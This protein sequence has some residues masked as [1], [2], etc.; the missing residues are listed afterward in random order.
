M[1]RHTATLLLAAISSNT[2]FC[3]ATQVLPVYIEDNHAG[4]YYWLTENLDVN[5]K[6]TLINFDAHS[7]ASAIFDS[8]VIRNALQAGA[9]TKERALLIDQWR[10][11]GTIQ[12]FSWIEPLMPAPIS[13]VIWVPGDK[14]AEVEKTKREN[15]A[16]ALIDGNLEAAPRKTGSLHNRFTV[17]D[18]E[19]LPTHVSDQEPLVV[20]IDLDYFSGLSPEEQS[21]SFKRVWDFVLKQ[22][23]LQAVTFAISRPYLVDENEANRLLKHAFNAPLLLPLMRLQ[24]EPFAAVANDQSTRAKDLKAAGHPVPSYSVEQAPEGLRAM[25]LAEKERIIVKRDTSRWETLLQKWQNEAPQFHLE[26]KG[27]QPSTDG[28]W[29]VPANKRTTIDVLTGSLTARPEHVDWSILTPRYLSC[30]VTDLRADQVGFVEN[31]APRPTWQEIAIPQTDTSLQVSQ[32]D[33]YFD[34]RSKTGSIRL[35]ASVEIDGKIR[36]TPTIELRRVAGQGLHAALSEQFGLPYLFGSGTLINS[37]GTG[38]ETNLGADC[39]NFIVYAMRR[40]GIR[41]P[42]S[43]PKQ[44][45]QY[46]EPI[47]S[48]VSAGIVHFTNEDL[49]NGLIVHL[50]SH[51]AAVMEDR[52]PLGILDED[53]IV[54][55]QLKG[56]PE[57]ITLG[58]L[59]SERY[60][61]TFDLFRVPGVKPAATLIFGGDV[62]LGRT[63]GTKINQGID[64]FR[65]ILDLLAN[66]SLIAANLECSI[67]SDTTKQSSARYSFLSPLK[68]AYY[69]HKAGFNALSLANNHAL[70]LGDAILEESVQALS[71]ENI[72]PLGI[73]ISDETDAYAPKLFSLPHNKK[74]ALLAIDDLTENE[75]DSGLGQTAVKII[76]LPIA[77]SAD[78]T[79]L[80]NAITKAHAQ[81]DIIA[82]MVHWGEENT[83]I[84]TKRQRE[85]A[86]WLVDHGVDI[87]IGSHPHSVQSLDFYHGRP[88][89]Y[90]LGN[91]VFDGAPTIPS[92]NHG[93]LLEIGLAQDAKI[94][95]SRLI[96]IVLTDGLPYSDSNAK[97]VI[98]ET[99]E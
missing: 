22:H 32:L 47:A 36:R 26:V 57:N 55:H 64:P 95:T 89:A 65:G 54:A 28:V 81:A 14:L 46:L 35:Y 4:S 16:I 83:N 78:L 66:R 6:Y 84:V 53:D 79:R 18:L 17:S 67:A 99:R 13:K 49:K 9:S 52:V 60:M 7:D 86:R 45:K 5:R 72:I 94:V 41:I 73:T 91:L 50:G 1:N 31:A 56:I 85:F 40:Q 93:A 38:P 12:S 80:S 77:V 25:L 37:S 68:S 90:S 30:N 44:L 58:T 69:L 88:I 75:G 24:Y 2:A 42:W 48:S 3:G 8:D 27:S 34:T 96:P 76:D 82:C 70:D 59:L 71:R 10:N 43:D 39:A 62:M 98:G 87:V 23:N 11:N 74:I 33:H 21:A 97:D 19:S 51:V 61:D 63:I 20:S 15:Q 29:R 92:W